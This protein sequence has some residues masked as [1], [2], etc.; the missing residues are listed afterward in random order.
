MVAIA[1]VQLNGIMAA[2]VAAQTI[3]KCGYRGQMY[4]RM[5]G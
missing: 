5:Q 1:A 3:C 4:E 2:R